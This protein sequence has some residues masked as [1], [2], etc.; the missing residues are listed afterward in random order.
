MNFNNTKTR[1]LLKS[2]SWRI[3]GTIDTLIL[4]WI[5][6]GNLVFG[7]QISAIDFF[8]KIILYYYHEVI[9]NKVKI[10]SIEKIH[11]YKTFSWRIV[12][13]LST[14]I[15]AWIVTG[16]PLTGFKISIFEFFTKMILY[17]LHEKIWFKVKYGLESNE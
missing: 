9:W 17:Y 13:T 14:L 1:H 3:V 4:S 2:I 15:I 16:N 10:K 7:L 6:S 12:G 11:I 8:S 5:I